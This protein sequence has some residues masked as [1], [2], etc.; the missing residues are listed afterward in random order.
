MQ[1][2]IAIHLEIYHPYP[3]ASNTEPR[4]LT[5]V[6]PTPV[7]ET[8]SNLP[9]PPPVI[10]SNTA[11]KELVFTPSSSDSTLI[12]DIEPVPYP[13][14]IDRSASSSAY[15]SAQVKY[16]VLVEVLDNSEESEVRSLYPEAFETIYQG[17]P[18]LQI[19]AF[20]NWDK[21]KSAEENLVQLGLETFLID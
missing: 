16:K 20:S 17:E 12:P 9:A 8:P 15:S 2:K 6:A 7:I 10:T 13:P 21:A 18:W 11:N 5:R 4:P 3:V 1:P 14:E 19:G